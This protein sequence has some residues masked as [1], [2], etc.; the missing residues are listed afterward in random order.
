MVKEQKGHSIA[1]KKRSKRTCGK[2]A[3]GHLEAEKK[4]KRT[5]GKTAKE[6]LEVEK[7]SK[8]TCGKRA[9]GYSIEE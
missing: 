6:D 5:C 9:K 4:S 8:R 1:Q 7:K 3:K 2:R